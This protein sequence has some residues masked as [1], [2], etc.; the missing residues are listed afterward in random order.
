MTAVTDT[1]PP[2]FASR[3]QVMSAL[4][5]AAQRAKQVAEQTGTQLIV[6][7]PITQTNDAVPQ[8]NGTQ[9]KK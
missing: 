2:V 3:Q 4:R 9:P 8:R 5:R 6:S 1:K 7:N